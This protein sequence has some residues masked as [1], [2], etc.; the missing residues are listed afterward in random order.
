MSQYLCKVHLVSAN[1][2]C[3]TI[4]HIKDCCTIAFGRRYSGGLLRRDR[5]DWFLRNGT[6]FDLTRSD[7]RAIRPLGN[8]IHFRRAWPI[9][10][11]VL[12]E[13]IWL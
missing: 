3:K 12:R 2:L 1:A 10:P 5:A 11:S 6:L 4:G 7:Y 8:S 13:S 9:T